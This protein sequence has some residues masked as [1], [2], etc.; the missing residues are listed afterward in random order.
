MRVGF[1]TILSL[2]LCAATAGAALAHFAIDV[3]G[4]YALARDS[5]DHLDHDSRDLL[6][7]IALIVATVLALRGLHVCCEIA[8]KHRAR[9]VRPALRLRET[10]AMF[11]G[12]VAA[13]IAL[14]PAMEYLDGRLDGVPVSG[15]DDA[16]GGSILLGLI[17]TLFCAAIVV[18]VVYAIARWLISHRDTVAA[19]IETLLRRRHHA[20]APHEYDLIAQRLTPRRRA[21]HAFRLA[22]RGPPL[23]CFA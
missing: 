21:L 7:G 18:A 15:L 8:A 10:L 9:L 16:F 3:V 4:D 17:T 12:A 13:S 11:G 5:Y 20:D 19:I 23:T 14:V 22:K 1:R 2:A 6:T